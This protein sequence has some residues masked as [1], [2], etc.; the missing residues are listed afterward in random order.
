MNCNLYLNGV[1]ITNEVVDYTRQQSLCNSIG[2][3]TVTIKGNS[4]RNYS[5]GGTLVVYEGGN[6]V[7]TYFI[8]V[9]EKQNTG[10]TT[11]LVSGQDGSKLLQ[12]YFIAESYTVSDELTTTK[13]WINKFLTEAGISYTY[14]TTG[15]GAYVPDL[16]T[17]GMSTL[18]DTLTPLLQYNG[19]FLLFDENNSAL[20]GEVALGVPVE[21]ITDTTILDVAQA[22]DDQLLRNRAIVWGNNNPIT[23]TNITAY[24]DR[25]SGYEMGVSDIRPVVISNQFIYSLPDAQGI[26][27]QLLTEF[28]SLTDVK[29][30]RVADSLHV[31]LGETITVTSIG[32][33]G[34]G[35]ITGIAVTMG[36]SGY[37]T[38]LTL[39]QRC[40]RLVSYVAGPS[41]QYHLGP[42][43]RNAI[44]WGTSITQLWR[45]ITSPDSYNT[46]QGIK[47]SGYYHTHPEG[48]GEAKLFHGNYMFPIS[49]LWD[50]I[51]RVKLDGT[52]GINC[53]LS[54]IDNYSFAV[55]DENTVLGFTNGGDVIY[56]ID[57]LN[58]TLVDGLWYAAITD[59]LNIETA[60]GIH[61]FNYKTYL[62]KNLVLHIFYTWQ[63]DPTNSLDNHLKYVTYSCNSGS[64]GTP[65][66]ITPAAE[67]GYRFIG[68][69]YAST[70]MKTT[71]LDSGI[72]GSFFVEE[73]LIT[74]PVM[75]QTH[76]LI[77]ATTGLVVAAK[78]YT[79]TNPLSP[80]SGDVRDLISDFRND[81]AYFLSWGN[82]APSKYKI[83][84]VDS[85]ATL[86]TIYD[87]DEALGMIMLS[88]SKGIAI[89]IDDTRH[90]YRLPDMAE[91][92]SNP[93]TTST[94]RYSRNLD[95]SDD[96]LVIAYSVSPA[97]MAKINIYTGVITII[98]GGSTAISDPTLQGQYLENVTVMYPQVMATTPTGFAYFAGRIIY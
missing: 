93:T 28:S 67:A 17:L 22:A 36:N 82:S 19:W 66:D 69:A 49:E 54:H 24:A 9:M 58:K 31:H 29:I 40:P 21:T 92:G 50:N 64:W 46:V 6:K 23:G 95:D 7:G 43:N 97:Q 44:R 83:T 18:Y 61:S 25:L 98:S 51:Y 96:S 65:Q 41:R 86:S 91:L 89:A 16:T 48:G 27:N 2:T 5:P 20:I 59:Y 72:R 14:L 74:N 38:E 60:L 11:F 1:E 68:I 80:Y 71:E 88:S 10:K 30:I 52:D 8:N 15:D 55:L 26:A 33:S 75:R 42:L 62:D 76:F 78:K 70:P 47:D 84:A 45:T 85:E 77:F 39:D 87:D 94:V 81:S 12:D 32:W 37:T 63:A 4:V 53:N 35:L 90:F 3:L 34:N 56:K 79:Y 57:Y 13:S 73:E